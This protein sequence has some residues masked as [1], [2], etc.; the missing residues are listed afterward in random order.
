MRIS[1]AG[2]VLMLMLAGHTMLETARDSLFLARLSISQLPWTYAAIAVSALFASELNARLRARLPPGQLL[3]STLGL[4]A[5]GD[6]LFVLPFQAQAAWAPLA[7]Y[8][9]IAVIATLATSQFWLLVSELFTVVEAKRA[10]GAISAGGLFG[11]MLGAVGARWVSAALGDT[12]LLWSGSAF[13]LG[14]A[15]M[16]AVAR[17]TAFLSAPP[18]EEEQQAPLA[19]AAGTDAMRDPQALRYLKRVLLL[20]LLGTVT[21]T[22][23]DFVFK[24][25]VAASVPA[26]QLSTFFANFNAATSFGALVLQLFVLPRLLGQSGIGRAL[27][28]VP[29]TLF[30]LAFGVF[31]APAL[32]SVLLL[33]GSDA[34]LRYSL[35][36]N[37][38]EVLYL[39]LPRRV[40]ARWKTL[41][42]L[43]GQRGGQALA[44][45]GIVA[46][47][48]ADLSVRQIAA[49]ALP[50]LL[51]WLW[52]ALSIEPRYIALFRAR[53]KAGAIET[54]PEVPALDLR[55][56]EL[57]VAALGSDDDDEVLATIT[58]LVH[59]ERAH[60][61]PALLL[62]HPS[63]AVVLRALEVFA[64]ARR[65]DY[66]VAARRLLEREDDELRA[67]AMLAL[68]AHMSRAELESELAL[69]PALP[70]RAALLLALMARDPHA[71]QAA[72]EVRAGCEPGA[73][74]AT[75]LSFA[76][77]LRLAGGPLTQQ[78]A[79]RLH[80]AA[81]P[82]I[83]LEVARAMAAAP[84]EA[85]IPQL[86][87][88]LGSRSV[89][90]IARDAL[91]SI[92][93]PALEAL[94][95]AAGDEHMPRRLRAHVPRSISHFG[96]AEAADLLLDM[97]EHESDG[98]V[99]FKVVRGLGQLREHLKPAR[100]MSR[101]HAAVRENLQQALVYLSVRVDLSRARQA[102]ATLDTPGGRLLTAAL[103]N[104]HAFALD[105][106]VRLLGLRHAAD[107]IHNI[108]Q[109]LAG[110][111]A[112]LRAD[113]VE[114]LVHQAPRDIAGA[115]TALLAQGDEAW[116]LAQ[117]ATLLSFAWRPAPY[118]DRL[119]EL[120]QAPSEAVRGVAEFHARELERAEAEA[121]QVTPAPRR[122]REQRGI[123]R[124][125]LGFANGWLEPPLTAAR[126]RRLS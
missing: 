52:I 90:R 10:F 81:T 114:L 125:L 43:I 77:A 48:S 35:L 104:K 107:V 18:A 9:Y 4:G 49:C 88:M 78:L 46:F 72:A 36:R 123:G 57:L 126:M 31:L 25:Q 84:S 70:V 47:I 37:S 117:A 14:A 99:R 66:L 115:L 86:M 118:A 12:G 73:D 100:R 95:A 74:P 51:L 76:R 119:R 103:D 58:L 87:E 34:G 3:L 59:Y 83:E 20:G 112:R 28:V 96:S 29:L 62:Y 13:L 85:F 91:V 21:A 2:T 15:A 61:I 82:A 68:S 41:V 45:L 75:R 23:V 97:L 102:D 111:D 105:R 101:V 116:R 120:L 55:S 33:R 8:V 80:L 39:P 38:L 60:M 17:R 42:D 89:R 122:S 94:R 109:A 98:W 5:L 44:S 11:A 69:S 40:R 32:W 65:K 63:R 64:N 53:V 7:F 93:A 113:G 121:A 79:P 24:A 1:A 30:T 106:A 26:S 108:R 22:L 54:R 19:A 67:A 110:N 56:L 16:A 71:A 92:G 124:E 6:L 27:T 50:L